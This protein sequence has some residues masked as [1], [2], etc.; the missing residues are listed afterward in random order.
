MSAGHYFD[1]FK[2]K[3]ATKQVGYFK[4]RWTFIACW[5]LSE[6]RPQLR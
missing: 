4:K 1:K 5:F 2:N 3:Q 6:I